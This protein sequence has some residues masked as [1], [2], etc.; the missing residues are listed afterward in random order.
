MRIPGQQTRQVM[1]L[2]CACAAIPVVHSACCRIIHS[3]AYLLEGCRKLPVS[4]PCSQSPILK[5]KNQVNT[6]KAYIHTSDWS[7]PLAFQT[8]Q[9]FSHASMESSQQRPHLSAQTHL[10]ELAALLVRN[11]LISPQV[12]FT[13]QPVPSH[14]LAALGFPGLCSCSLVLDSGF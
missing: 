12:P 2:I 5:I 3:S 13:D 7:S 14:F 1:L 4:S 10:P 9:V 11:Q 6:L 8:S